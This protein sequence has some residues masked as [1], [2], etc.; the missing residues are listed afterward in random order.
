MSYDKVEVGNRT[1]IIF[2]L[3]VD[4]GFTEEEFGFLEGTLEG[5]RTL[6]SG[7]TDDS[8]SDEEEKEIKKAQENM[9]R[10]QSDNKEI[11]KEIDKDY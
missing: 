2:N 3:M 11:K 10:V 7:E 8:L 1:D 4:L 9:D 6:E 5:K